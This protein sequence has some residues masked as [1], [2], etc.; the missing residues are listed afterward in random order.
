MKKIIVLTAILLLPVLLF[1]GCSTN[2]D[3]DKSIEKLKEAGFTVSHQATTTDELQEITDAVMFAVTSGG[4]DFTVEVKKYT[5]L[6]KDSDPS[7]SCQFIEFATEEQ[8]QNYYDIHI[9][10]R[11]DDSNIKV[12]I[13]GKVVI[14]TNLEE[15]QEALKFDFQ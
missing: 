1:A 5:V 6:T 3:W 8:A 10:K 11:N 4:G 7:H 12:A 15:A 13:K 9:H 14:E 2:F